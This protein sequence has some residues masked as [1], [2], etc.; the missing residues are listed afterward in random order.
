LLF[1]YKRNG[2]TDFWQRC[3]KLVIGRGQSLTFSR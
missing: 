1:L 3:Q 2:L